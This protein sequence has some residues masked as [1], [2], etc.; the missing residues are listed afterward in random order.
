M[1]VGEFW[2]LIEQSGEGA[3]EGEQG[4]E[5]LVAL[6]AE[7]SAEEIMALAEEEEVSMII[8][9][10][11]SQRLHNIF[12]GSVSREVANNSKLPVLLLR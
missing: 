11:R 10:S 8:M 2:A 4:V 9:G 3:S 5:R 6:L 7:L 1:D 12:M